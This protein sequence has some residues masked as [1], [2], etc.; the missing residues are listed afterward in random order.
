MMRG[1]AERPRLVAWVDPGQ[2]SLLGDAIREADL[3]LVAV[4]A[5][6]PGTAD[7]VSAALGVE[8]AGDLRLAIQRD[9]VDLLWLAASHP[10]EADERRLIRETGLRA[11]TSEP[12][13]MAIGDLLMSGDEATT[14][15]FVPLL[16]RSPGYLAAGEA[17]AEFGERR[18]VNVAVASG[19]GQG[20]LFARLFDAMDLL[21]ALGGPAESVD[22]AHAGPRSAVPETLGE[23]HGHVTV[24]VRYAEGA[25]RASRRATPRAAGSDGCACSVQAAACGSTTPGTSGSASTA[26]WSRSTG[27]PGRSR[28]AS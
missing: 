22:A 7:A 18:C 21:E 8:R 3:E 19:P 11:V 4:G 24:N 1:M 20:S 5:T 14:A 15:A 9:D 12:R 27:A 26:P 16:R 13:P 23:L 10:I 17:L 2:E 25:A 28:R 6:T